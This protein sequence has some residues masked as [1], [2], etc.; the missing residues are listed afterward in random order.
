[1]RC[2]CTPGSLLFWKSQNSSSIPM[3]S[4][5]RRTA[6]MDQKTALVSCTSR[7]IVAVPSP[8]PKEKSLICM[9]YVL[10]MSEVDRE[11][12]L[13]RSISSCRLLSPIVVEVEV[14]VDVGFIPKTHDQPSRDMSSDFLSPDHGGFTLLVWTTTSSLFFLYEPYPS[15]RARRRY[16]IQ[17]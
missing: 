12:I 13:M 3:E 14:E 6:Y 15:I 9:G 11:S 8:L 10:S 1:M 17:T 2:R 5:R 16:G 4:S 7:G